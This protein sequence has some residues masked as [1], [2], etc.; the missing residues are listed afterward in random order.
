VAD[1]AQR[2]TDALADG[3][4]EALELVLSGRRIV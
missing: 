1:P 2:G 4:D 3:W